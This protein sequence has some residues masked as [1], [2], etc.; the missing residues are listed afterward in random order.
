MRRATND[1][2]DCCAHGREIRRNI[3]R[4]RHEQENNRAVEQPCGIV[5]S[6]I[7]RQPVAADPTNSGADD[8]NGNHQRICQQ[9]RPQDVIAERCACLRIRS[10]AA[11]VIVGRSGNQTGP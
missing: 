11:R 8:L 10:D 9:D 7:G 3:D 1:Q 6:N 5:T 4:I 2:I